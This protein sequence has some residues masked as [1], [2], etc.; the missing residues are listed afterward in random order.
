MGLISGV[1]SLLIAGEK[2]RR[3]LFL[4]ADPKETFKKLA[5]DILKE[6]LLPWLTF[7]VPDTFGENTENL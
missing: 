3:W 4:F 7:S 1:N 2:L 6:S 5:G